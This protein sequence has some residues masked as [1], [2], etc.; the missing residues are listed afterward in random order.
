MHSVAKANSRLSPCKAG[1]AIWT[2]TGLKWVPTSPYIPNLSAVLGYAMTGLGAQEGDFSHGI[3]TPTFFAFSATKERLPPKS[4]V[5][6]NAGEFPASAIK[7]F[8]QKPKPATRSKAS[9]SMPLIGNNSP[10]RS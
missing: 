6:W 10:Y 4:N 3:G 1:D 7:L 9:I 8:K 2:Q 5:L